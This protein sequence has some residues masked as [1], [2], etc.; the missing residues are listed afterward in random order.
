MLLLLPQ[1]II[2]V[3]GTIWTTKLTAKYDAMSE[4]LNFEYS[5]VLNRFIP[6]NPWHGGPPHRSSTSP[7]WGRRLPLCMGSELSITFFSKTLQSSVKTVQLGLFF[8]KALAAG[9][10]TSMAQWESA[11]PALNWKQTI[12]KSE[13]LCHGRIRLHTRICCITFSFF[14]FIQTS[15]V[16]YT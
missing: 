10:H 5:P 8:L 16:Y 7:F 14:P 1:C 4:F 13:Y 3:L 2:A 6:E 11:T 15:Q 9:S 12:I